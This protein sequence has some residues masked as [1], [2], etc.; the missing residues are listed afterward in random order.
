[1]APLM[2]TDSE[3]LM[4]EGVA[5][6]KTTFE[7][8][9]AETGW[10]RES[11]DRIFCHQVGKAHQKLLFETLALS[12]EKNFSTMEFLGNTGSVA[13]PTA[14]ALGMESGFVKEG[15]NIALLGIGSGINVMMLG[16]VAEAR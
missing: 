12:D 16:I 7:T 5:A 15:D 4:L 2:N 6:A 10:C 13:L 9:L 14:A 11:I 8:F 3:K 1:M